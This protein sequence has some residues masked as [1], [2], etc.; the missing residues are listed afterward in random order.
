MMLTTGS[1]SCRM[2]AIFYVFVR[3]FSGKR[4]SQ[5]FDRQLTLK[6]QKKVLFFSDLLTS[7]LKRERGFQ[8]L[9][10][11]VLKPIARWETSKANLCATAIP[12]TLIRELWLYSDIKDRFRAARYFAVRN[13]TLIL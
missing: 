6:K 2:C 5:D 3:V 8:L 1:Q 10:S 11:A 13:S 9:K 7:S 12:S 4:E